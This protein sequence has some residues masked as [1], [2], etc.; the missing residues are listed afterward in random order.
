[1]EISSGD[2]D[3]RNAGGADSDGST[4]AEATPAAHGSVHLFPAKKTHRPLSA[5]NVNNVR[6]SWS[7]AVF[8]RFGSKAV[9]EHRTPNRV[10]A[11]VPRA[12]PLSRVFAVKMRATCV[13]DLNAVTCHVLFGCGASRMLAPRQEHW[14][15]AKRRPSRD[16]RTTRRH[17]G[18]RRRLRQRSAGTD[19]RTGCRRTR[20]PYGEAVGA[21][22]SR[23]RVAFVD[24]DVWS[25]CALT[26]GQPSL[27][28]TAA[29]ANRAA[30]CQTTSH[31]AT[32]TP[33]KRRSAR[34]VV[35]RSGR[36][37][38]PV[39]TGRPNLFVSHLGPSRSLSP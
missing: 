35:G 9:Q 36:P 31:R 3:W 11:R 13:H 15:S 25:A 30:A 6:A 29:V 23:E 24:G 16:Q 37:S 39:S 10:H 33:A 1:V 20:G 5:G 18:R 27:H 32:G 7:A 8:C 12:K 38:S 2:K 21:E 17:T 22:P 28:R 34:C 26:P 14:G 4:E 19:P